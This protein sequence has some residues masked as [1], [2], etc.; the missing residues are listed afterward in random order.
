MVKYTAILKEKCVPRK[1]LL[2]VEAILSQRSF[3]LAIKSY[4]VT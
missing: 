2:L 1:T 3:L 4:A